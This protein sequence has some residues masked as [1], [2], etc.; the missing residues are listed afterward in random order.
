[1]KI[2]NTVFLSISVSHFI[3]HNNMQW[4][5]VSLLVTSH[6]ESQHNTTQQAMLCLY[7]QQYGVV[8]EG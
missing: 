6:I 8:P 1:M 3:G 2:E 4:G 5:H 7:R